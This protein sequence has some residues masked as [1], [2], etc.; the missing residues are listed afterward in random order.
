MMTF[1]GEMERKSYIHMGQEGLMDSI[2][3]TRYITAGTG[4]YEKGRRTT[5]GL[6]NELRS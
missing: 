2:I 4:R 5:E 6:R 3:Y 1:S